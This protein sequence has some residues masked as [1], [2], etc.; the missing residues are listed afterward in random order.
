MSSVYSNLDGRSF[1]AEPQNVL[2]RRVDDTF[3]DIKNEQ[4]LKTRDIKMK[5]W[6]RVNWQ[7][8]QYIVNVCK[9]FGEDGAGG[10]V[11]R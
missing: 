10:H 6:F 3:V 9:T 1:R 7:T 2:T 11:V 5:K 4:D 8:F